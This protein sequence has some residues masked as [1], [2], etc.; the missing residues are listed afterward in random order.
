MQKIIYHQISD[1]DYLGIVTILTCEIST[2]KYLSNVLF[3]THGRSERK[4]IIDSELRTG[5]NKYRFASCDIADDGKLLWDSLSYITPRN[6]IVRAANLFLKEKREI[7][8]YSILLGTV[9][10]ALLQNC[11]TRDQKEKLVVTSKEAV[12]QIIEPPKTYTGTFSVQ[13]SPELHKQAAI[14]A[15]AKKISLNR[16]VEDLM[17]QALFITA[18]DTKE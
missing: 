8:L 4:I 9:Q 12:Y 14:A 10:D 1:K 7:L 15:E 3:Y 17:E 11:A 2:K 5:V 16:F 6:E 18:R 13:I